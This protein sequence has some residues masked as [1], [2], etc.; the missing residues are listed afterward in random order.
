MCSLCQK[1]LVYLKSKV[2]YRNTTNLL[3]VYIKIMIKNKYKNKQFCTKLK[4]VFLDV[5]IFHFYNR[6]CIN[7]LPL[8]IKCSIKPLLKLLEECSLGFAS[9]VRA[10][11]KYTYAL[12]IGVI[13]S[14][15]TIGACHMWVIC[16]KIQ[17][18]KDL[19]PYIENLWNTLNALC[20]YFLTE[21]NWDSSGGL[22][23]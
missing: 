22:S 12:Y 10:S 20:L 8:Q 1:I 3:N 7:T 21:L 9:V 11:D 18:C 23:K 14:R 19:V 5:K 16:A 4:H 17:F 15:P 2:I 13:W 6:T